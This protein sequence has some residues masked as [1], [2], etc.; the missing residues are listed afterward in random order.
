MQKF[1]DGVLVDMTA[2]EVAEFE[3]SR[4]VDLPVLKAALKATID[5]AAETERLKYITPGAGQALTYA[6]KADQAKAYLAATAPVDA[7][8]PLIMAEIGITGATAAEVADVIAASFA[9]WQVIGSQIEAAR[10]GAKKAIDQAE[11]AE[12]AQA[13]FDEATV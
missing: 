9:A 7:D 10:L 1:V 11:T 5:T 2:K 8:Y 13:A 6:Q 4:A 3:T 12:Q